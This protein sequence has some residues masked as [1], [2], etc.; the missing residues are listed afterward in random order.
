MPNQTDTKIRFQLSSEQVK[1]VAAM[2]E[3]Q[4]FRVKFIDPKL[5]GHKSNLEQLHAA[6]SALVILKESLQ[7]GRPQT[8]NSSRI[9]R[10]S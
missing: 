9:V 2:V 8:T 6:E 1:A 3:D 5:P 10:Q 4:L 7:A